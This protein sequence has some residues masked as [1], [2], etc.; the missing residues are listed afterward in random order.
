MTRGTLH[1]SGG[2]PAHAQDQAMPQLDGRDQGPPQSTGTPQPGP[3]TNS[4]A[5][6]PTWTGGAQAQAGLQTVFQTSSGHQST[7]LPTLVLVQCPGLAPETS[8]QDLGPSTLPPKEMRR[9]PR[10]RRNL[11]KAVDLQ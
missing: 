10:K 1:F 6:S 11:R 5:L 2:A 4:Q 9:T 3:L 8:G 7:L